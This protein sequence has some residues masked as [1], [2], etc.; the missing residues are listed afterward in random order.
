MKRTYGGPDYTRLINGWLLPE[1]GELLYSL[2]VGVKPEQCIA[3]VGSYK[4]RST[5]YLAQGSK[6]G[7]QARVYAIDPHTGSPEHWAVGQKVDTYTTFTDNLTTLGL[8]KQV[9][10]VRKTSAEAAK[11]NYPPIGLLF[12]DARHELADVWEDYR[13]WLPKMADGGIMAFH[14]TVHSDYIG[15]M[16]VT[17]CL[18]LF[19]PCVQFAGFAK[20]I[21][22]LAIHGKPVST[23]V[24]LGNALFLVGR[25][26]YSTFYLLWGLVKI[27]LRLLGRKNRIGY[28]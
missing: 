15:P 18:L 23:R 11:D 3:E 1:E 9:T 14:D 20:S 16:W 17:A 21:T 28:N 5:A 26:L 19:N 4:G 25:T 10:V 6:D 24:R 7:K 22:C 13:L 8:R 12:V 27:P 2:A